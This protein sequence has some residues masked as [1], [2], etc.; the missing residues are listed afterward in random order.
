MAVTEENTEPRDCFATLSWFDRSDPIL[1]CSY[2][3]LGIEPHE[4]RQ[5]TK[6]SS[7]G[8]LP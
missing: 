5:P 1:K 6:I 4:R 2:A 7:F 8:R 3:K